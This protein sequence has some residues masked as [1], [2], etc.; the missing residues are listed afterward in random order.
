MELV[1]PQF[2]IWIRMCCDVQHFMNKKTLSALTATISRHWDYQAE[3]WSTINKCLSALLGSTR[4][5]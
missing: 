4:W 2:T 5:S 3:S 1:A